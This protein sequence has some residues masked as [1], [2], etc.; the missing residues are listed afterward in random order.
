MMTT[1]ELPSSYQRLEYIERTANS[2]HAYIDIGIY[3]DIDIVYELC[4]DV[5]TGGYILGYGVGNRVLVLDDNSL[6]YTVN[7]NWQVSDFIVSVDNRNAYNIT[8]KNGIIIDN[9]AGKS[10]G[11]NTSPIKNAKTMKLF[12][13]EDEGVGMVYSLIVFKGE[14]KIRDFV[15]VRRK[16]D[17]MIGM[18]DLVGRKFYTSPNGVLFSGGV[19]RRQGILVPLSAE[20]RAA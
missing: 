1:K 7:G 6:F 14:T 3:D 4:S 11:S 19:S 20:R 17:G 9:I 2:M 18:Y 8:I 16:V 5:R 10:I 13:E 12:N 15:P